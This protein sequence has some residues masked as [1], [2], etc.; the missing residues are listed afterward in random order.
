VLKTGCRCYDVSVFVAILMSID[1]DCLTYL[2]PNDRNYTSRKCAMLPSHS[3]TL[4]TNDVT[5]VPNLTMLS[6]PSQLH[7]IDYP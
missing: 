7:P 6:S 1:I 2:S 5:P 3:I 4:L